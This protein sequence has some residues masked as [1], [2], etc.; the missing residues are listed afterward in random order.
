M[1]K[2]FSLGYVYVRVC[3]HVH[4]AR[5]GGFAPLFRELKLGQDQ[6]SASIAGNSSQ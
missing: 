5:I 2:I 3:E 4:V 1:Y 6:V